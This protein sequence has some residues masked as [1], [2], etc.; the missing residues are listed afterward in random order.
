MN[1]I[2]QIILGFLLAD[3]VTGIFHW[4]EDSY[5]DYCV[6]IPIVGRIAKDN[7]LHHYFPRTIVSCSYWENMRVTFP[8]TITILIILYLLNRSLFKN[9]YLIS[10]FAFFCITSN[11]LHRFSHMR[12]CE[13]NR[14]TIFLQNTG[15]LCSHKHHLIHHTINTGRYC[16]MSEYSNHI[17]DSIY[18]W[19]ALEYIVFLF[20]GIKPT[21]KPYDD[22]YIIQNHMHENSKLECPDKPTKKDIDELKYNLKLYKNCNK[23][24]NK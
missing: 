22:Y 10:S 20:T 19:R 6:D 3:V 1:I 12:E 18:F 8:L 4:F 14:F 17:L 9:I 11:L 2:L 21:R 16:V 5:L 13:N 24:F 7:E 23:Y 15:I